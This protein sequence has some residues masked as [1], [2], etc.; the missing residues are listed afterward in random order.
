VRPG[1]LA[2]GPKSCAVNRFLPNRDEAA[3]LTG[4]DDVAEQAELFLQLGA[5]RVGVTLGEEGAFV[6]SRTGAHLG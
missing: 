1:D 3:A 5:E 6:S 4:I 2:A